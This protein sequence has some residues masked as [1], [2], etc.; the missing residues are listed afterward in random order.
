MRY[1]DM[2]GEQPTRTRLLAH[3]VGGGRGSVSTVLL[4][5]DDNKEPFAE[6]TRESIPT[7]P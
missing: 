4:Y 5:H 6:L 1:T 7:K 2:D 3:T